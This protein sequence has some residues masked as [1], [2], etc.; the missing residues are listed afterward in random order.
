MEAGNPHCVI[1][2]VPIEVSSCAEKKKVPECTQGGKEA[3][4]QNPFP[5]LGSVSMLPNAS[6]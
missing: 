5:G 6:I 3:E 2:Q 1:T 4:C